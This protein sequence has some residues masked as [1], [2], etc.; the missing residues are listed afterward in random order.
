MPLAPGSAPEL[1]PLTTSPDTEYPP[2]PQMIH[3]AVNSCMSVVGV[4]YDFLFVFMV[5]LFFDL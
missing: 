5:V 1:P 3:V 2:L 4:Q